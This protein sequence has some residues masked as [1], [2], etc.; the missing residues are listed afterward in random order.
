MEKRNSIESE[1]E[2]TLDVLEGIGK[3]EVNPYLYNKILDG[4][5]EPIRSAKKFNFKLALGAVIICFL[6]NLVTLFSIQSSSTAGTTVVK[7]ISSDST[8]NVQIKTF[9]S[10]YL[11]TNN[12]YFY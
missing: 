8:R 7:V 5:N 4:I 9:A 3:A 1:T 11:S 6:A 12:F 2:K 10:E